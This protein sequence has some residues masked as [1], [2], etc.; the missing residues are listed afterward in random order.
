MPNKIVAVIK[1]EY[2]TRVK[3]KGF[4]ASLFLMPILMCGLVLL[5]SFLAIMEDKTEEIRKLAVIDETGEI[6]EQMRAA[7][8]KHPTFQHKG[9]LVYQLHEETTT[10]ADE[11][12]ALQERVRTKELYAYL[13]I[14]KDVFASGKVLFYAR[15]VTNSNVQNTFRR[16]ISDIVRDKR[17]AESGYSQREVRQLMRSVGFNAYAVKSGKGKEGGAKVESAIETG[18]RLGLGYLLVF[19]LYLFVIIYANSIMRSVLEEKTT[20]IVEVIISSIKPYQLLLGKLIGVCSVCLTMFA[21]WVIFGVLLV[22]N[23][24]PLLGIFGIDSLPI[25]FI[26]VIGTIKASGTEILT[27]FFVYFI[28]G[29]FMYSTLYAVVGAICGSEEEAQQTGGPLTMLIIIPFILMFQLF[30]I[31]DST[32]SVLLSHIPFFSPILMFMRI[33]VLMPPLWEILLNILLMCAT[34]LLVMLISGKIYRVGILMYGKRP[35][36]AQLW[37]WMR[38]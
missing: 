15:T 5:S 19:V 14:P 27:Y 11:K 10:T 34:V 13:E 23:I 16:I 37:Q 28:M 17:F 22:M 3:S 9:E 29:F 33:N 38:Y 35:T 6:F 32:L 4:I 24:K 25:Q 36:L 7:V 21:I 20:R 8:A 30:R 18:A 12:T 31:P 2:M 26:Q 1:R